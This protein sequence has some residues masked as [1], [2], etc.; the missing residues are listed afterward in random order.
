MLQQISSKPAHARGCY[1]PKGA[2]SVVYGGGIDSKVAM[3]RPRM[4]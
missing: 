2:N 1:A 4:S 3:L